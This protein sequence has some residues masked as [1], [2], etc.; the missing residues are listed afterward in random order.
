MTFLPTSAAIRGRAVEQVLILP[1]PIV[2]F[3]SLSSSDAKFYFC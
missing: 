2:F 1:L 3:L